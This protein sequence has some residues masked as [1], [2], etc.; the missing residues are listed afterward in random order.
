MKKL[1]KALQ[2]QSHALEMQLQ[3]LTLADSPLDINVLLESII[4]DNC[5]WDHLIEALKKIGRDSEAER[6]NFC[7]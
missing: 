3:S 1:G 5:T 6:I 4:K 7:K 2:L